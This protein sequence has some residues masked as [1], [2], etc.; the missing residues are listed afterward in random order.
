VNETDIG[1]V[2]VGQ[3]AAFTVSAYGSQRFRGTVSSVSPLGVTSSNVVTYPVTIDVDS[4]SL[5][6]S[7][8]LPDM[9]A[10]VSITTAQRAGVVLIPA[11]AVTYARGQLAA[12]TITR[13]EITNALAQGRTLLTTAQSSDPTAAQD[14]LTLSFVLERAKNSFVIVPVVLGLTDGSSDVV[15]AGLNDGDAIVVG[16][17]GGSTGSSSSSSGLVPGGGGRFGGGTGGGTG[18]G[19]TGGTGRGG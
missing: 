19:G 5:A 3:N 6:G 10:N 18:R 1:H 16:Q 7:A 13:T 4:Q 2:A 12:G 14:Q 9:T 8:L 11:A 17:T 15:V